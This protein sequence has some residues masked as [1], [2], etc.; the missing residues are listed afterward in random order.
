MSINLT[1]Q[2]IT[3]EALEVRLN[4]QQQAQFDKFDSQ[5][6]KAAFLDA[7][8]AD[9]EADVQVLSQSSV[10]ETTQ[11]QETGAADPVP[12]A[13]QAFTDLLESKRRQGMAKHDY[14]MRFAE[15]EDDGHLRMQTRN[16]YATSY[17]EA[18][19]TL[20]QDAMK[21][22]RTIDRLYPG[23]GQQ[24]PGLVQ[25]D[26]NVF[27]LTPA[28]DNG[29]TLLVGAISLNLE[30]KGH[31]LSVIMS[32]RLTGEE[33]DAMSITDD[34]YLSAMQGLDDDPDTGPSLG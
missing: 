23:T 12:V 14:T 5:E 17:T 26:R 4:A 1:R 20:F 24:A 33:L 32:N 30:R 18:V 2:T 19:E 10:S 15:I 8:L 31:D 7:L 13:R 28:A 11:M 34:D 22:G 6:D 9:D 3:E 29:S 25:M 21:E 27:D 16:I